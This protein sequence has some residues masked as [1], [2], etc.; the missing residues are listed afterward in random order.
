MSS[1]SQT[2]Q[3]RTKE[4]IKQT[5]RDELGREAG[6]EGLDYWSKDIE[7]GA[8]REEVLA[9]IRRSDEKWLGD[10]YKKE[11]GR[12]LGD[13][14]R[15]WWMGDLRGKGS[16]KEDLTYGSDRPVQTREQVLANIRRSDEWKNR[17]NPDD[18][19]PDDPEPDDPDPVD[20]GNGNGE[21]EPKDIDWTKFNPNTL[22]EYQIDPRSPGISAAVSAGNRMTD[23][24]Y[25][26]FLPNWKK[27]TDLGTREIG[28][29][30]QKTMYG[31]GNWED[32]GT[33]DDR[34]DDVLSGLK[35][36]VPDY[37]DPKDLFD[38]YYDK[39]YG[40]DARKE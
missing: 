39:L 4:W 11:L 34:S 32:P 22:P 21:Y 40:D 14:G 3:E 15:N 26:K 20:P 19:E 12:D 30:L 8:T 23:H 17:Q 5:Y 29:S 10:T 24:F 9:N 28:N 16:G 2:A 27:T 6:Q 37:E 25:S 13:E 7:G 36:T 31:L 18:P 35:I 38:Y 1:S 33:P